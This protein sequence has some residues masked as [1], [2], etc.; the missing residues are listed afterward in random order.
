MDS[1]I[2][3]SHMKTQNPNHLTRKLCASQKG[4]K[5]HSTT[6]M[7]PAEVKDTAPD[8]E[9]AMIIRLATD[10]KKLDK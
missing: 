6:I 9:S 7:Y 2:T 8:N 4:N 5:M 1:A 10:H 3:Q